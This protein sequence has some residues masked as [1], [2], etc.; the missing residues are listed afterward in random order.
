MIKEPQDPKEFF[1]SHMNKDLSLIGK[2]L[3]LNT[4]EVY[5]ILHSILFDIINVSKPT[6]NDKWMSKEDRQKWENG[7]SE[8]CLQ[9]ALRV[10][11]K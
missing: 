8:T 5:I 7:F 11:H 9:A 3:N 2:A 4:D 1:W 6:H 10:S